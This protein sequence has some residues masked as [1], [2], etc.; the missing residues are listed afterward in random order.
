MTQRT[1]Q[2]AARLLS[3]V[4]AAVLAA[5]LCTQAM[6]EGV[7]RTDTPVYRV[8]FYAANCFNL[9]DDAGQ[10]SGYGYE[11][12]QGL[13]RYMQCTF[14]YVGYDKTPEQCVDMLRKGELDLGVCHLPP[15]GHHGLHLHERQGHQHQGGGRGL[16]HL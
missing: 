5:G 13:S 3:L 2:L 7:P 10:R 8:S 12:M 15:P 9:Q 11:M 6:A 1:R 16:C 14:D 4:L